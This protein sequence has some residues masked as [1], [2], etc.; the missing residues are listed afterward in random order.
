M[1]DQVHKPHRKS[2]D[3][4]EKKEHTGGKFSL[5]LIAICDRRMLMLTLLQSAI[6]RPFLLPGPVSFKDKPQDRKM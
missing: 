4:K 3:R 2:K 5:L 1:E 6:P